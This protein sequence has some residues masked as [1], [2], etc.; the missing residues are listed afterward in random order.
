M[1]WSGSA[2]RDR[3]AEPAIFKENGNI[4]AL[5]APSAGT[6]RPLNVTLKVVGPPQERLRRYRTPGV[7]G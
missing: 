3:Q 5:E 1:C 6:I 4:I 7:E 2:R